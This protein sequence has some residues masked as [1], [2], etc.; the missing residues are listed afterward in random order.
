V[1]LHAWWVPSA[2]ARV[3]TLLLHGNA[4]NL[5]HR[6]P[7]MLLLKAAGSSVLALDYRGY[8]RSDG[9][10]SEKGLYADA[11]AAYEHLK[12]RGSPIVIHGESLGSAVA[13]ELACRRPCAGL[14]L[15]APFTSA[16]DVAATVLPGIGPLL[17]SGFD[18]KQRIARLRTPLLVLHGDRDEVI[19]FRLGRAL[20]D[21]APEPKTFWTVRGA[22]HNDLVDAAGLEYRDRLRRFYESLG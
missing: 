21:A 2:N 7:Y 8:G 13:V 22:G 1:R 14:V 12:S 19:P 17:V 9:R 5:T 6:A 11:D 4:G 16:R 15:E 10:P 20:F 3:S 18:S